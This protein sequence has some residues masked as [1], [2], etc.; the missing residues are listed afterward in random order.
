[1]GGALSTREIT[2]DPGDLG[3]RF[4]QLTLGPPEF[5]ITEQRVNRESAANYAHTP[6]EQPKIGLSIN[7]IHIR[8]EEPQ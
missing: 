8:T 2:L 1:M 6:V 7:D 3:L 5:P 4:L